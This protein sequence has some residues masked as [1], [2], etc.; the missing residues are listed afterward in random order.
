MWQL[1]Q[2]GSL[3]RTA[4]Q[5]LAGDGVGV[6]PAPVDGVHD[7]LGHIFMALEAGAGVGVLGDELMDGGGGGAGG[8]GGQREGEGEREGEGGFHGSGWHVVERVHHGGCAIGRR[9]PGGPGRG[10]NMTI[11]AYKN[12]SSTKYLFSYTNI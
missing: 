5:A 4:M 3:E 1:V 10:A 6:L 11:C 12:I 8:G 2:R 9:R 7:F